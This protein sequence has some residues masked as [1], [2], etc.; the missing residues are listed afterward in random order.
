M[1]TRVSSGWLASMSMRLVMEF[2]GARANV[3]GGTVCGGLERAARIGGGKDARKPIRRNG[4]KDRDS[5]G[6]ERKLDNHCYFRAHGSERT[7]S[8]RDYLKGPLC[9]RC[10]RGLPGLVRAARQPR[11]SLG[12]AGRRFCRVPPRFQQAINGQICDRASALSKI[13]SINNRLSVSRP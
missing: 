12:A 9:S 2:S 8:Q 6:G 7:W 4:L 5:V 10:S 1:T 13:Y 3:A 11:E